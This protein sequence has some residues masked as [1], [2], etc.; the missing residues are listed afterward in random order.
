MVKFNNYARYIVFAFIAAILA[1]C[2]GGNCPP[3]NN[4]TITISMDNSN[5]G[6]TNGAVNVSR[7]PSIV[8]QFSTLMN[9]ETIN[10]S[11]I[12]L[13]TSPDGSNPVPISNI[14][15]DSGNS[16]FHFSPL[17]AL[18][19]YT[20]Y[21]VIITSKVKAATGIPVNQTTF[22]FTTGD[23]TAP[24]VS[25]I[26]PVN[27]A[28]NVSQNPMIE[29]QF[30]EPV[31]NVN[32]TTVKLYEFGSDTPIVISNITAG[33]NNTYNFSPINT[34]NQFTKYRI[35]FESGI[36]DISGN[37]LTT[38]T[39]NFTTGDSVIPT[40]AMLTPSNNSTGISQSQIIQFQ[41]SESVLYVAQNISLRSSNPNGSV[42]AGKVSKGA[43]NT[44][45]FTADED[46]MPLTSYYLIIES[47][48][49][50][51]SGNRIQYTTFNFT[52][53]LDTKSPTVIMQYPANNAINVPQNPII[54]LEFSES[55]Q[56]VTTQNILLRESSPTG[57]IKTITSILQTGK[58]TYS[59][60]VESLDQN[61]LYYLVIESGVT[62]LSANPITTTNFSFTTGL[63]NNI[64]FSP[65]IGN[66]PG[67]IVTI[68]VNAYN[69][70]LVT[71]HLPDGFR[72][73]NGNA[74]S[75][76]C[77]ANLSCSE[78][79]AIAESL[80]AGYQDITATGNRSLSPVIQKIPVAVVKQFAYITMTAR[81][82]ELCH[83]DST[84]F[85]N[86]STGD[87]S[88]VTSSNTYGTS[89]S[90]EGLYGYIMT[91]NGDSNGDG[92]YKCNIDQTTESLTNCTKQASTNNDNTRAGAIT[93]NGKYF[94]YNSRNNG[95]VNR[96]DVG[97]NGDLT[98]C[99][100]AKS[101]LGIVERLT[102]DYT[103]NNIFVN[104][105][106][107]NISCNLNNITG[108]VKD[109]IY[110]GGTA[111]SL[112]L[113]FNLAN[114]M[115]Y[116]TGNF[117]VNVCNYNRQSQ[118]VSSCTSAVTGIT[119]AV[120]GIGLSNEFAFLSVV[121]GSRVKQC[122]V[123]NITGILSGCINAPNSTAVNGEGITVFN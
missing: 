51:S 61:T 90:P 54:L 60:S 21:Y 77:Y 48:I 108:E 9:P 15:A 3:D 120:T 95:S 106:S 2:S 113:N 45:T 14:T 25:I 109:C 94:Y 79:V 35:V 57:N 24:M 66:H 28:T 58:T 44:Y 74:N 20:K 82:I 105:E 104:T 114:T 7:T 92:I 83:L 64:Y 103:G 47:G 63:N 11:T 97:T 117:G 41:F 31:Q 86:C 37:S 12:M 121:A 36:T 6:I 22:S 27:N 62:D 13:S 8:L 107:G 76:T 55:V 23:F 38:T 32:G 112:G 65:I 75:F 46:L 42:V 118:T 34:L 5:G 122:V 87:F 89:I 52:V 68:Q 10:D 30:S 33:A 17:S 16:I 116:F 78:S 39:F 88:G 56:N 99:A 102:L 91:G 1:A 69:P 19:E 29:I 43:D 93:T 100:P 81:S 59:L 96:C 70:E 72:T 111:S 98:N 84:G 18:N 119:D 101:G 26:S 123:D 71:V 73:A 4:N 85:T 49:V 110:S 115:M 67:D 80:T 50:D 40:V 53:G